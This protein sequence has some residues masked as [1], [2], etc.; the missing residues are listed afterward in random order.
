M[1][2]FVDSVVD[3]AVILTKKEND[4]REGVNSD[5]KS[6]IVSCLFF[7]DIDEC[8]EG[9]NTCAFRCENLPGSYRC[10]CPVGYQL[11]VDGQHC[12]GT[13]VNVS[14]N[15][16][17]PRF[18]YTICAFVLSIVTPST[19]VFCQSLHNLSY[20]FVNQYTIYSSILSIITPSLLF[21]Q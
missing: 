21:C 20:Y 12:E 9:T 18:Y 11:S 19:L 4:Q 17:T 16:L 15:L 10:I 2:G 7:T 14:V 1:R 5:N 6:L 3:P 8:F 13:F